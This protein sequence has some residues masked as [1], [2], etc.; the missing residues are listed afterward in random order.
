MK[1]ASISLL[2]AGCFASFG[3]ALTVTV[4]GGD[5]EWDFPCG[6]H[7]TLVAGKDVEAAIRIGATL[8]YQNIQYQGI[9]RKLSTHKQ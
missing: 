3:S 7:D 1:A 9:G 2:L 4:I 8:K 5:L 6:K